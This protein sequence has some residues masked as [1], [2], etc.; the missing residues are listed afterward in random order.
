M[1]ETIYYL[2]AKILISKDFDNTELWFKIND[3]LHMSLDEKSAG[4][5]FR[6]LKDSV[7]L[8][9]RIAE[10]EEENKRLKEENKKLKE[11]LEKLYTS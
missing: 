4:L 10:L 3:I 8:D 7:L 11:M 6:T 1:K 2:F 9:K 5:L